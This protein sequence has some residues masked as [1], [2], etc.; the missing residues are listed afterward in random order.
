M[1]N[2]FNPQTFKLGSHIAATYEAHKIPKNVE[3]I[4]PETR[5]GTLS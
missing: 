1:F 2:Q 3:G 4:V 5:I